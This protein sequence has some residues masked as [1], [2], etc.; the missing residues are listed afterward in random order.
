V[1]GAV[2]SGEIP[3]ERVEASVERVLEVKAKYPLRETRAR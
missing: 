3:R 1:V 2:E